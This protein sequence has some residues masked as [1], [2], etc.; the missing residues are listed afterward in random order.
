ML[1]TPKTRNNLCR[2]NFRIL[3]SASLAV[4][5]GFKE[6]QSF[7]TYAISSLGCR[8]FRPIDASYRSRL[9]M[10]PPLGEARCRSLLPWSPIGRYGA[11]T[12]DEIRT[13]YKNQP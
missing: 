7:F 3:K 10:V 9:V 6:K 1:V 8:R 13:R 11:Q 12:L 4:P 5:A 2:G